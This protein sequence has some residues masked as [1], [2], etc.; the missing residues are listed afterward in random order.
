M[1][2]CAWYIHTWKE[3][4]YENNKYAGFVLYL[5]IYGDKLVIL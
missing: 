5:H 2:L 1:A 3:N 4:H